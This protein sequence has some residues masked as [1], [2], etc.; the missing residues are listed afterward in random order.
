MHATGPNKMNA[1][2]MMCLPLGYDDSNFKLNNEIGDNEKGFH[3]DV[4]TEVYPWKFKA[5]GKYCCASFHV[6]SG[7]L[8]G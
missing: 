6:K 2:I 3:I 8:E 7:I 1:T 5:F 4:Q